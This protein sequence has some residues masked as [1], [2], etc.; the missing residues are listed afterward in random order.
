MGVSGD[1]KVDEGM[2]VL[3]KQDLPIEGLYAAGMDIT[4]QDWDTYSVHLTG[5]AFGF[6]V[7]GGRIAGENA[8]NYISSRIGR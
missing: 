1:L 3:N 2:H 7:S 5:H 6:S 4:N 8:A